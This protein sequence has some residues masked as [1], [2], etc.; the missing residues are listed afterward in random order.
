MKQVKLC[1]QKENFYV[2]PMYGD[3]RGLVSSQPVEIHNC[4][5]ESKTLGK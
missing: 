3:C 4:L 5:I 2:E 1:V